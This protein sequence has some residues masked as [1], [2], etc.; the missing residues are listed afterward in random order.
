MALFLLL[1]S[2]QITAVA[3]AAATVEPNNSLERDLMAVQQGKL[4]PAKFFDTLVDSKVF[5]LSKRDVLKLES[6]EDIHA[7]VLPDKNGK[8]RLLAVFTS[9]QLAKRVAQTYPEYRYG[10]DTDFIWVLAHAAPGLSIAINPGWSL[11]LTIPSYGVLEMRDR[12]AQRIQ[13]HLK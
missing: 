5:V 2:S 13:E 12:Y 4:K 7:L 8:S 3:Q 1:C 6:P 10:I 11:G 9:G